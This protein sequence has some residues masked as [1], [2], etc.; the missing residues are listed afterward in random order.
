MRLVVLCMS[1]FVILPY[2]Y[3]C[4]LQ[5]IT[6]GPTLAARVPTKGKPA[7][8]AAKSATKQAA[9]SSNPQPAE[10]QWDCAPDPYW[11][12]IMETFS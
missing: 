2:R 6:F 5:A 10:E 3:K 8:L 12:K 9:S 11:I 4:M 1:V 7:K